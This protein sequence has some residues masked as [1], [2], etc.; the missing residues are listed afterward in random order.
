MLIKRCLL[1]VGFS[2]AVL[3][4]PDRIFAV[5]PAA[6]T[7]STPAAN[8]LI[9]A[10]SLKFSVKPD[11]ESGIYGPNETVTWSVD[12]A[13]DRTGLIALPYVVKADDQVEVGKGTID[14]SAGPATITASRPDPGVLVTHIYPMV[15]TNGLPIASG[16]AVISPEKIQPSA[17]APDD[18]DDFW[19]AKLKELD[20]VPI[21]PKVEKEDVSSVKNSEGV[22]Y[23]KVTLDNIR[24]THVQGQL[25][26]PTQGEKFPAMLMVQ[27][28]GVY[29]L[30]KDQVIAQAK[31]GWL[32]LNISAHDLPIDE[33][34]AFYDN[35]K[36]TTL[37][38]YVYI[39]SDDRDTS[40]FLRMLLG[41]ARA[42]DYLKTRPDWDGKTI[43]VTGT[44][45]GGLQSFA[46]AALRPNDV[47]VLAVNVPAGADV[48]APLATPPRAF[49]WPYWLSN[50]GPKDRDMK[51]VQTTAGYYDLIYFAQ[52]I[53][54]SAL[55]DCGL[56]DPAARP[57]G[58]I[59]AYNQIKTPKQ[60]LILPLSDHYGTGGAQMP[61]LTTFNK[62]KMALQK[63]E[64]LP[65]PPAN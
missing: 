60:L 47:N 40:Y 58:V 20:A 54:A 51:K 53:K 25:A 36:A 9:P 52:R 1:V 44:S 49:G 30:N 62:W 19:N 15:K 12:I 46:A 8:S 32:A 27:F 2:L 5:D 55:V 48:Y 7:A 33:T 34:P 43:M 18:F 56:I 24:G 59:A 26:R 11:H 38:D 64:P 10:T 57:T 50:W 35:L 6:P 16:G 61:F 42:V 3:L 31:P 65:I 63:G 21:N 4:L 37:K 39:G 45:Q 22:D 29:P 13:G 28:A 14:L 41:C 17:P 23:Y